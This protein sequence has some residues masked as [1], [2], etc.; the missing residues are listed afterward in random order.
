MVKNDLCKIESQCCSLIQRFLAHEASVE[1]FCS[2]L[3]TLWMNYRDIQESIKKTWDEP[4]DQKLVEA[5]LRGELTAE[6]FGK[7][8]SELWGLTEMM[9]FS[10]MINGV[11]SA[12]SAF[13]PSPEYEWEMDEQQLGSEVQ[14]LLTNYQKTCR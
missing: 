1:D 6:E 7:L 10:R 9:D 4:Y 13:S 8:Y 3:T 12:C 11:H 14:T 5:R 2:D